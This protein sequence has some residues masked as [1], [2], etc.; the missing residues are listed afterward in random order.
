MKELFVLT[1]DADALAV[2]KQVLE[3]PRALGIRPIQFCVDRHTGRDS[4]MV[5]N[6]P[7]LAGMFKYKS[8]YHKVM[9]IWDHHGSGWENKYPPEDARDRISKRLDDKT[10]KNNS[11]AIVAVPEL[12]EWLWHNPASISRLLGLPE[13][14]LESWIA[15]FSQG[16]GVTV[17]KARQTLPKEMFESVVYRKMKRKPRPGDFEQIAAAASLTAWQQSPSFRTIVET[18]REWFPAG[19]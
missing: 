7:E 1:A 10:W 13:G 11:M 5:K 18:L 8:T 19:S 4:G 3:S 12:E 6:G 16:K 2:M 14:E 15:D 9:L 17:E